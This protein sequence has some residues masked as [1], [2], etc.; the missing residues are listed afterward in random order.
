MN[1]NHI[2]VVHRR[3]VYNCMGIILEAQ[4]SYIFFAFMHSFQKIVSDVGD[5]QTLCD[6]RAR[7]KESITCKW[8]WQMNRAF[9]ANLGHLLSG[10]Q[11]MQELVSGMRN[12]LPFLITDAKS[13]IDCEPHKGCP[14]FAT[15]ALF[16]SHTHLHV[17]L[18]LWRALK[19]HKV[20]KSP[21]S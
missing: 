8:M 7:H 20:W 1:D 17:V 10:S 2:L 19:P 6:L 12:V 16:I 18:S 11:S 15:I 13:S 9:I 4:V 5:F 14:R 3:W 21:K